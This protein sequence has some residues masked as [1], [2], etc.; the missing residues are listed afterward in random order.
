MRSDMQKFEDAA[1][2]KIIASN[3][4]G[5][6]RKDLDNDVV[7]VTKDDGGGVWISYHVFVT[8]KESNVDPGRFEDL[9]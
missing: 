8:F 4:Q 9:E 1:A 3:A 2:R 5:F 7:E 6:M